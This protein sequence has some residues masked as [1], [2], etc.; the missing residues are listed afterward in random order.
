[1]NVRQLLPLGSRYHKGRLRRESTDVPKVLEKT[2]SS[3]RPPIPAALPL[4]QK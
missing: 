1:M 2:G 4:W 3:H